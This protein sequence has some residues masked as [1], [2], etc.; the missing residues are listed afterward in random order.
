M[1]FIGTKQIETER[2]ILR[3]LTVNDAEEAYNNWCSSYN[4]SKY[5]MW[6]KH[7]NVEETKKLFKTWEKEYD[8]LTTFR[9]IVELKKTNEL[10]GTID[11]ASKRYLPFGTCEIGY[12]YGEK[13][14]GKGYG[15]EALKA[16]IKYLFEEC[17]AEVIYADFMKNN[18]GSGKVMEKSGMTFEGYLRGRVLDKDGFRNDLGVCSITKEEYFK[19]NIKN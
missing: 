7:E 1:K 2:L 6:K 15:T 18:P 14:W 16:V 11:V 19:N 4:V 12:C 9:W 5:V 13:F 3:K 8:D 10:I 17:D